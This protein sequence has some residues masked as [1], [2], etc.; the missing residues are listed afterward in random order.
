MHH[1]LGKLVGGGLLT[2]GARPVHICLE[3]EDPL[4]SNKQFENFANNE[5]AL[6]FRSSGMKTWRGLLSSEVL[7]E[8]EATSETTVG[9]LSSTTTLEPH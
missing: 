4:A 8:Q 7:C 3:Y 9:H 1:N 6:M 5:M 2:S